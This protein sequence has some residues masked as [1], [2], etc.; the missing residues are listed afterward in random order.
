ME[1]VEE[2]GVHSGDSACAIPPPSLSDETDRHVIED[3]TRRIAEAL[4]VVGLINVQYA[5]KREPGVRDRGQPPRQPHRAVRGQGHRRAAGEGRRRVM[6]GATL[7]ELRDEGCCARRSPGATSAVK[8]AVLPFNR[9]PDADPCSGPRC[10]PPARS[11][12]S[13]ARSARLRQEPAGGRHRL[14]ETGHVFLS[15]AD[16]DKAVG[17]AAP[18]ALR[19]ARASTSPPPRAPPPHSRGRGIEVATV[20][21]KLGEPEGTNAVDL[22][23]SGG[24]TWWSTA[25][26]A[27]GRAPTAPHP[28]RGR[29]A[30]VPLLT[31]ARPAWPPPNG[32]ADWARHEMRVRTLQE[33]HRGG[34]R[35]AARRAH[36]RGGP[37]TAGGPHRGRPSTSGRSGRVGRCRTRCMTASG[38]AGHGAEL[39]PTSTCRRR[40]AR[41]S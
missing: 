33:Y 24:S 4:D 28:R 35:R 1:H 17:R 10:A 30:P 12:A 9:F 18:G 23:E 8:E 15:L 7:A 25:P 29:R 19:R 16:R 2:A 39:A 26:G 31:T 21:A 14:P 6:L 27:V 38:T 36:E 34:R 32:M 20:V 22:I 40:S 41:W 37:A 3:Y 11:W 13:T 5:V